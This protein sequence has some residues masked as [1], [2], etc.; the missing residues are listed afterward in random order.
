MTVSLSTKAARLLLRC[1]CLL[2]AGTV[3]AANAPDDTTEPAG[4]K[5]WR[6]Q[7]SEEI[8]GLLTV[9]RKYTQAKN[10]VDAEAAFHKILSLSIPDKEKRDAM[11]EMGRMFE[12]SKSYSKIVLTYESFLERFPDDP[13]DVDIS[14]RLGRACR[15]LG[16]FQSALGKFY[17]ALHDSMRPVGAAGVAEQ[18]KLALRAQFEIAETHFAKG[19][20]AEARRFYSR[21]VLL[22]MGD[23]D[24]TLVQFRL[25]YT[26]YLIGDFG[27]SVALNRRFI[28]EHPSSEH[29]AESYYLLS[30]S[31]QKLGR[32]DEAAKETLNLLKE[33]D[34]RQAS[35][36][37]SWK[38]WQK[39]AGTE[40]G[41]ELYEHGD[42]KNALAIFQR[43]AELDSTP[44]SRLPAVYQIGLC[45]ER[46]RLFS[47]AL[48]A[49]TYIT[50][51]A[52]RKGATP[53]SSSNA[54]GI[55]EM[56]QWRID[57][58]G[59][60]TNADRQLGSVL[61]SDWQSSIKPLKF[62]EAPPD[63]RPAAAETPAK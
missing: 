32:S 56:A 21:L 58:L 62:H 14:I 54:G 3:A 8:Q 53:A 49:Y 42:A 5:I 27:E 47:R 36:P 11:L 7:A 43:V 35:A 41:S 16:A 30:R 45:F 37:D 22:D 26:V 55:K 9:A 50:S 25:A 44:E 6:K 52:S 17:N 31:L 4:A 61:R 18:K 20:Y 63:E 59:W 46:L 23:D 39:R 1:G 57:Y 51:D 10:W 19:D 60:I 12:A 28:D 2:M 38:R 13:A 24:R 34:S 15:E 40:V 48:E 33:E 29:T